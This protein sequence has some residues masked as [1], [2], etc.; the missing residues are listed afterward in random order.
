MSNLQ[1]IESAIGKLSANEL[2]AFRVWFAEFDAKIWDRQFE[3]DVAAGRL[4]NLAQRAL[5][6][7]RE[8]RCTDL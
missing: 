3:E 5:Q 1:E 4:D 6:H 8:G 2:A 7:L